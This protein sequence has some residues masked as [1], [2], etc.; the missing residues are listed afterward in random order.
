MINGCGHLGEQGWITIGITRHKATNASSTGQCCHCCKQRPPFE[1][2]A[3]RISIE[4]E[5]VIPVPYT[6]N[7][8]L[9]DT[10]YC[11]GKV[12]IGSMLRMALYTYPDWIGRCFLCHQKSTLSLMICL[13]L[14]ATLFPF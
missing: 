4:R 5:K 12:L 13:R 2:I 11:V 8:H 3:L 10:T 7:T 6:I 9:F 1:V 14:S